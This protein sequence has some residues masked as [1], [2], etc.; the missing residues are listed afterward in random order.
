MS[1]TLNFELNDRDLEHFQAAMAAAKKAAT[2]K[3]EQ[4]IIDCAANLLVESQKGTMPDFI[5]QRLVRLD[6][7]IAMVRDEAWAMSGE[8]R[9][10]APSAHRNENMPGRQVRA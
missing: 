7:L 5:M 10:R 1:I 9:A 8:D 3:S 4:E 2:G 6:D